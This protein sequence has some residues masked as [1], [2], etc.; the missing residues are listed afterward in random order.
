MLATKPE[1]T[2]STTKTID[3]VR[4]VFWSSTT[5]PGTEQLAN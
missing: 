5:S 3:T 1:T 2:G 4:D